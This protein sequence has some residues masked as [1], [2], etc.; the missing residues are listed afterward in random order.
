M[1][2]RRSLGVALAAVTARPTAATIGMPG[3]SAFVEHRVALQISESVPLLETTVINNAFNILEVYGPD[4]VAIQVVAFAGGIDLLKIDNKE[5]ERIAGLVKQG[6]IF[7]ACMNS[8]A[9]YEK[10]TGKPF[11]RN[12]LSRPVPAGVVHLMTLSEHGYTIIRP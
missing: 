2:G 9:G 1:I 8:I 6:V 4:K 10:R 7:D 11:P 5:S 12:P 3:E